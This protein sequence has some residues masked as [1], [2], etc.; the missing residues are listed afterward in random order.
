MKLLFILR[1]VGSFLLDHGKTLGYLLQSLL[2]YIKAKE[3]RP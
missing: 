3:E 1:P 2:W